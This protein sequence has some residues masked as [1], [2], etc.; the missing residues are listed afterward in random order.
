[1]ANMQTYARDLARASRPQTN[2]ATIY[3]ANLAPKGRKTL[4]E[5]V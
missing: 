1:M 3:L 5:L 2:P 4:G